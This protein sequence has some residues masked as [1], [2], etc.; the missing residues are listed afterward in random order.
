MLSAV[1]APNDIAHQ[2]DV[3][4]DRL[5]ETAQVVLDRLGIDLMQEGS[6]PGIGD[7]AIT[8]LQDRLTGMQ[9]NPGGYADWAMYER[10][11]ADAIS[12]GA[13]AIVDAVRDGSLPPERAISE[14]R[15]ACAEARW[16]DI[17]AAR[18]EL[19]GLSNKDRDALVSSFQTR[20]RA[21]LH[22]GRDEVLPKHLDQHGMIFLCSQ[23]IMF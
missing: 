1:T 14:F 9:R 6:G 5:E 11:S 10:T 21:R 12:A 13:G 2:F 7:I 23:L 3:V 16:A 15:Y 8:D 22:Q 4:A 18:P 19:N 20:D 17:R